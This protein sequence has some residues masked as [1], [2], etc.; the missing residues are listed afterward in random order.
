MLT[1]GVS[2]FL[3]GSVNHGTIQ[4]VGH[5]IDL[6]LKMSKFVWGFYKSGTCCLGPLGS[7]SP[8]NAVWVRVK[9]WQVLSYCAKNGSSSGM[10]ID[11]QTRRSSDA[12]QSSTPAAKVVLRQF[13][14]ALVGIWESSIWHSPKSVPE[15]ITF[16]EA[17]RE[18]VRY[19]LRPLGY[20]QRHIVRNILVL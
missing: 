1:Q 10:G 3:I 14:S 4:S 18:V 20:N 15:M 2:R 19:K 6:Q 16:A 17:Y 13:K 12:Q 7:Q 11:R 5:T 8:I 9:L